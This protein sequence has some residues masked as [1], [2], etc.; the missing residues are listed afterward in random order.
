MD[1]VLTDGKGNQ[2]KASLP[3]EEMER[4]LIAKLQEP[5]SVAKLNDVERAELAKLQ[6]TVAHLET[7]EGKRELVAQLDDS[8]LEE[9]VYAR[10]TEEGWN[11]IGQDKGYFHY[12]TEEEQAK[13]EEAEKP[14]E[15][16][17]A[18]EPPKADVAE[19]TGERPPTVASTT[20]EP[21]PRK[22]AYLSAIDKFIEVG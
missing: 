19:G 8:D 4:D 20:P 13:L 1:L 3:W 18:T 11:K 14:P 16:Q 15:P 5:S 9:L 21:K 17:P 12:P 10:L 2:V 22:A 6:E 7:R